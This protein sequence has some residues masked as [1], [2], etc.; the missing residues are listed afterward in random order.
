MKT[1][2]T[3]QVTHYEIQK[4]RRESLLDEWKGYHKTVIKRSDVVLHD[5]PSR[6]MRSGVY[7]GF[8]GD[9]PT[10]NLD[11]TL[12]ELPA[13][14][15]T[16][17]H[18]HSWDAIEFIESGT[19]WTEIDGQRVDWR[20]WDTL[21]LP[22][23]A[24]HRHGN[25]GDTPAAF[26][27]WS[28][29]PMLEQF[30]VALLEDGGDTPVAKLPPRPRQ[31]TPIEGS[32]PLARRTQRLAQQ[33]AGTESA[34]L[35]TRFDDVRGLITKRGARSLFLVDKSIGYHTAGLSA[36]MHELAP[37]L[38]QSR[39]RH[40][41]EAWLYVV[42]GRGHS[43]VDGQ[44]HE[45]EAGD[46]IVVDHWAWHQHFNDDNSKTARLIRVH[47]FDALYDMMRILLDPL[48]L[49]EELPEL[50]APDLSGVSWPD[51]FDGRPGA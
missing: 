10:K 29:Q 50:D 37:G 41:G 43:E 15:T 28:V 26:H 30:G 5:V 18:R 16:T 23:W 47:N 19:G 21:H 51:H 32:D 4:R 35:I 38:Y 12:H 24:W 22:S 42:S 9:R 49:F 33:W 36:V 7:A 2:T 25:D 39:H 17:I 8:D 34:R 48:N 1:T 20:P 44:S 13:H 6:R 40:G 46:L 14:T 27:T 11:A 3:T 31:I 45:W